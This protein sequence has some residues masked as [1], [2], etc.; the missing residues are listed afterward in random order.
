MSI[1]NETLHANSYKYLKYVEFLELICRTTH[2]I[3]KMAD[4]A[5]QITFPEQLEQVLD[6][7]LWR[8]GLH[9]N[10]PKLH[11]QDFD[12]E[13][14]EASGLGASASSEGG[15]HSSQKKKSRKFPGVLKFNTLNKAIDQDIDF[16]S[17]ELTDEENKLD[18][19]E[20]ELEGSIKGEEYGDE[21]Y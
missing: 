11:W 8:V 6:L 4:P 20:Q 10:C 12:D 15:R 7:L 21:D 9:R 16:S 2:H 18:Q 13:S 3:F 1:A 19:A 17:V 14:D 5:K